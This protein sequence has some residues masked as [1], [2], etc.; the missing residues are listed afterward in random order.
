MPVARWYEQ[1]E[2]EVGTGKGANNCH[3]SQY[4][5]WKWRRVEEGEVEKRT[6]SFV[7]NEIIKA[8]PTHIEGNK[9]SEG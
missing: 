7:G 8:T 6:K 9:Y 4:K 5:Q 2:I 3:Q 1:T